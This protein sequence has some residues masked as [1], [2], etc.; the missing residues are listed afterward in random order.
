M[1]LIEVVF[2]GAMTGTV[3]LDLTLC[4]TLLVPSVQIWPPP[5]RDTWPY[6]LTWTLFTAS[7]VGV[8]VVG[9]LDSGSLGFHRWIGEA[10]TMILGSIV[11]MSGTAVASYAMGVLGL[12][13]AL[14]LEAELVTERPFAVSRNPGYVGDLLLIVGYVILTDSRLAGLVGAVGGV[15]FAGAGGRGAVAGAAVRRRLPAVPRARPAVVVHSTPDRDDW[16]IEKI[17]HDRRTKRQH[18]GGSRAA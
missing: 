2:W 17:V 10:G 7:F 14:G 18:H 8:L 16:G 15:V 3:L 13:G 6:R 4:A 1:S 11:F 12:R 9:G 5:G